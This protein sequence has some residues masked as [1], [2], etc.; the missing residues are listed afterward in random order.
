MIILLASATSTEIKPFIDYYRHQ[1]GAFLHEI[2]VLITGI[3]LTA[4]THSLTKQVHTKQPGLIIQA[5][6]AGCF[7]HTIPLGAVLAIKQEAIAD[8]GVIESG[9]WLDLQDMG[10]VRRNDFPYS[11]GWLPNKSN[12]LKKVK[13]KKVSA[14]SIN[15]ITTSKK[16]MAV[17]REKLNPAIES[18]EGA[19]LH[20]V[21]LSENIPF[22]Q[23]RAISNYVGERN[24][25]KWKMK[26]AIANL[27]N[28]L[29]GL[30]NT[31]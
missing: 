17:Y 19:A 14:I 5:G 13:L 27:N 28:E 16:R 12:V 8:L 15:E 3:G 1:P 25:K 21:A 18:M 26:E 9:H 6:I 22:L 23:I 29:I 31:I 10:L 4:A 30:F 7:D 11:N 20:Y 2:D 24:K